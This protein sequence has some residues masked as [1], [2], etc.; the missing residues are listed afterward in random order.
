MNN[1]V[2]EEFREDFGQ[3]LRGH[4]GDRRRHG[5]PAERVLRARSP[6]RIR[7]G[8]EV[9]AIDQDADSV[10]VHFKTEA[11]RYS[12]TRRLRDRHAPVLGAA[13]G[14][15]HDAVLAREAARDPAAQLLGLDEDPV[16]GPRADLGDRRRH[17]RRRDRHRP[18]DPAHELPDARPRRRPR[19]VLLASYTWVQD[20]ARWGAMDEETRLEE[21]LE[22]VAKIHPRIR[23]VYEVGASHAWY[24]DR[25]ANGAFALFEAG[26]QTAAPGGHRQA[27]GPDPLRGRALLAVPRLDPGRARVRDP[28]RAGDPRGARGRRRAARLTAG[29]AV[30]TGSPAG[31]PSGTASPAATRRRAASSSGRGSAARR[32]RRRCRSAGGSSRT[33]PAGPPATA[34]PSRGPRR[35]WTVSVDIGG[36]AAGHALRLRLR[37]RRASSPTQGRTRTLPDG[38]AALDP[39]RA[40]LVRE[41]QRRPLQRLRAARRARTTSHFILHLGDWIYEASQ[42]PPAS[43]TREPGHRAAV[44]PAPRVP[45]ARRLPAPLRPVPARPR[46]PGDQRRAPDHRDGRRP[47]VRRRRVARRRDRAQA[48]ARR[49]VGGAPGGGVPGPRGVAARSAARIPADPERVFR[50]VPIGSL[51]ELFLLDTRTRRDEP[52]PP[53]EM[54]RAGPHG[55]RAGPEGVAARRR[56]RARRR[57]GGCSATRRS[58]RAPGTTRCPEFVAARAREGQAHRP[59]R[60][61]AR[62]TTSG[63]AT[64]PSGA[65]CSA[66][67]ATCRSRT[68]SS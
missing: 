18:A 15:G 20:A 51:A 39:L 54:F 13:P 63:T 28:G 7:F 30:M 66:G 65:S 29:P 53:P 26:Q 2:V 61:R 64:R 40:G 52:V 45:D 41:V 44:R 33:R 56:W 34:S 31:A 59:R 25:F 47:R 27:R 3:G 11:G 24:D 50:S 35:D 68:S 23:E 57:A 12:V 32:G 14:R 36:L 42:T 8:A 38:D 22:D 60:D 5:Q 49:A 67:S 4:A 1:A 55:A 46:R 21:A 16:P 19:G 43:Q 6:D 48:R 58:W 62:T 37:G 9:H 17:L 10:T